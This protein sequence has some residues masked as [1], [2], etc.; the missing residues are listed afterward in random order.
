MMR[1]FKWLLLSVSAISLPAFAEEQGF[2][3]FLLSSPSIMSPSQYYQVK[4]GRFE[5]LLATGS[6][7]FESKPS[8]V[9]NDS[10]NQALEAGYAQG[11]MNNQLV[12]GADISFDTL[13]QDDDKDTETTLKP[14]VAF[15]VTPL[16]SLGAALNVVSGKSE[17]AGSSESMSYNTFTIGATL[18][19]DAWEG[20]VA[21]TTENKDD[22]KSQNNSP[23]VLSV[24]GRYKLMPVLSLG[25]KLDQTDH[26]ALAAAGQTAETES[27]Y[28][29]ILESGFSDEFGIEV[30]FQ[31]A[32]NV[33]G[34]KDTNSTLIFLG[35]QYKL[36][37]N[38]SIGAQI[39]LIT[40]ENDA[41]DASSNQFAVT[42]TSSM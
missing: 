32:S 15:N 27:A 7:S 36:A 3:N 6:S 41:F 31:S 29:L 18:H 37:S 42:L 1:S 35:G 17:A 12:I 39:N 21:V 14:T 19:Q 28:S 24:H 13:T 26:G 38:L 8:G 23:Q 20:S 2:D 11:L 9:T 40:L 33:S 4:G 30:A 16:L 25:L 5:A 22:K 10:T 34:I